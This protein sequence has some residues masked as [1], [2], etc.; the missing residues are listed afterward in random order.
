MIEVK[1]CHKTYR[2]HGATV[3]LLG[4]DF[5]VPDGQIVGILGENRRRKNH[6]AAGHGRAA[7]RR[8]AGTV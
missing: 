7:A 6:P 1:T 8:R 4:A 3:G 2:K 5:T